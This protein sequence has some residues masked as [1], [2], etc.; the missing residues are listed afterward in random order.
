MRDE[1]RNNMR[2]RG[3][4]Q[5]GS[6]IAVNIRTQCVGRFEEPGEKLY[7]REDPQK[8]LGE[9][10]YERGPTKETG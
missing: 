9:K 3:H 7:E 2:E 4:P 8:R 10:Q 5:C 1:V 6:H